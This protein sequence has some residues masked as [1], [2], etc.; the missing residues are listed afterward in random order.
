M[1]VDLLL[2]MISVIEADC[3]YGAHLGLVFGGFDLTTE[4]AIRGPMNVGG[5]DVCFLFY[6]RFSIAR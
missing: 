5:P 4:M 1:V 3:R 2:L 6:R